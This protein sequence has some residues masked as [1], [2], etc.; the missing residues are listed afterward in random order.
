LRNSIT[1]V[2]TVALS[3]ILFSRPKIILLLKLWILLR[4]SCFCKNSSLV[5]LIYANILRHILYRLL[6][7][8][9]LTWS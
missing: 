2:S 8:L 5:I 1:N 6:V 7:I 4:S 3:L 9:F